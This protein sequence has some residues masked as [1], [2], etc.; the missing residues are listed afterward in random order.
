VFDII[1]LCRYKLD[2]EVENLNVKASFVL[3]D[4]ECAQLLDISAEELRAKMIKVY[5]NNLFSPFGSCST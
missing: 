4:R 2:V 3:W 5:F 1:L